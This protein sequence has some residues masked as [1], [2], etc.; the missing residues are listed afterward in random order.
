MA[1]KLNLNR[2]KS[3]GVYTV[4]IDESQNIAL[5]LGTGRLVIGSSKRGPINTVV[6]LSD[7]NSA[8]AV[9]GERDT[10]LESKGSYFHRTLEVALR[11]GPVYA[12]NVLPTD[13]TLDKVTFATFNTESASFNSDFNASA[14]EQPLSSFFNTQ[15]LWYADEDQF[16]RTK[17]NALSS[18]DDNKIFSIVNLGKRPVTVW[19]KLADVSGYDVTVKEYYK[20]T[21]GDKVTI[22][23]YLHPDDIVADYIIE[24]IAVEGDW[25]D[26]MRLSTDPVYKTYFNEKGLIMSKLNGFLNLR[27][28]KNIARV[29]GSII[30]QFKDATGSDISID[31]V[32]N[33]LFSQ[34]ELF[35]ALDENKIELID[36]D[37]VFANASMDSHRI[38]LAGHGYTDLIAAD[39]QDYF[40]DNGFIGDYTD[41]NAKLDVLGYKAPVKNTAVFE[42]TT[43]VS[44]S[45]RVVTENGNQIIIAREG[46]QLYNAW[47]DGFIVTGN[48]FITTQNGTVASKYLKVESGFTE[49][50][51]LVTKSYIKI[52]CFDNV[53]LTNQSATIPVIT[54]VDTFVKLSLDIHGTSTTTK[55]FDFATELTANN[56]GL[57]ITTTKTALNKI[58]MKVLSSTSVTIGSGSPAV[59]AS[60]AA[61][62]DSVTEFVK[63][64][65][66]VKAKANGAKRSRF[67]KIVSVAGADEISSAS[68][69]TAA[70][71]AVN[72]T[73]IAV[74]SFI[75][76]ATTITLTAANANIVIG[77]TVAGTGIAA[78]TT[79]TNKVGNVLTLSAATT[80][81][82][83]GTYTFTKALVAAFTTVTTKTYKKF[84]VTTLVPSD[85]TIIGVD[86][87]TDIIFHKGIR[88]Y[89]TSSKGVKLSGFVMRDAQL[90]NGTATR[91][92]D[93]LGWLYENTN[94]A[95]TLAEGQAVDFRYIIDT[96]E[97]DIS[98]S[99]KYYLAKLAADNGQCL[100]ILNAP[101]YR[102]LE[103]SV[104]PSFSDL[105]TKLVSAKHIADGGNLDLNPT[106]TFKFV[107]EEVNGVPM[108][109]Y[110]AYFMPNLIV[111]DNG[112]NKSVPPAAYVANAF[113]NKYEAGR[114][115]SIVA[116]KNGILGDPEI[117]NVE[118]ELSQE[119]RDYLEPVGYNL[120]VRRRGFGIMVFTNNTAYQK[121]NSALNNTHV[122]EA[123]ATIEKDIERI[124]FNFLFDFNDEI[125]RLRIK[126]LVEGYL[127]RA[128]NAQGVA[129]Y[130]VVFDSTNNGPEVLSANSAIIDVFLDFPRGI[131]KFINRITITRVG[132]GLSSEATGFIPSF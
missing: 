3:S 23:S 47:Y 41:A 103:L 75:T 51:N 58:E 38:D 110:A 55:V 98:G 67:L 50:V 102:Q 126:T 15:K 94:I 49:V 33:R 93:I 99:S 44:D 72:E 7:L 100:A 11:K 107:D 95:S 64:N 1:Q 113:M 12:L 70:V 92:A 24:L 5:P 108:A 17:N 26:N 45:S 27:E 111:N 52:K 97:G 71:P 57:E 42:V 6:A 22:P 128:K 112:R 13:D 59:T 76:G 73:A 18:E 116:G 43:G 84:T 61:Y 115:F 8:L 124:L 29:N 114:P 25:S 53:A 80:A 21:G 118:Y 82:S 36:L 32:F 46:T 2:F 78:N 69:V 28:V 96:Y 132:G 125:T 104:E 56:N 89:I 81:G 86:I 85:S 122:R 121:I 88:N 83:G 77:C 74:N 62:L 16:N 91:Q 109:S 20:V 129:S 66:Y 63:P 35:C 30:P 31:R 120:I 54:V 106:T 131:H 101:S 37:T 9:Y 87:D 105:T 19:A 60:N 79:V 130:T 34:T 14:F 48:G 127:D 119:D 117:V 90:P 68:V 123:L 40:I 10:K 4:E 39:F 65:H